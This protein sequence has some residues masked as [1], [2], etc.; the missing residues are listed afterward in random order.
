MRTGQFTLCGHIKTVEQR[1]IVQQYGDW[2]STVQWDAGR[3][4]LCFVAGLAQR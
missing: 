4:F 3:G 2:Y 1:T